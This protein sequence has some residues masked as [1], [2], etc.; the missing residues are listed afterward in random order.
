[1]PGS[2]K[3]IGFQRFEALLTTPVLHLVNSVLTASDLLTLSALT[4][5]AIPNNTLRAFA[6]DIAYLEAW[7]RAVF[8]EGLSF[9]ADDELGLKFLAHHLFLESQRQENS[10]HGMPQ[11]IE[12]ALRGQGALKGAL[13]HSPSTVRRRFSSWRK[14]HVIKGHEEALTSQALQM[15]IRA[16]ATAQKRRP[17]RKSP[18][19]ITKA[20]LERMIGTGS[21]KPFHDAR[22]L[23]DRALVLFA[24]ASGGRR[25]SEM[26]D[27][28]WS[29]MTLAEEGH[30]ALISLS[31][32]KTTRSEDD[33]RVAVAGRA[34]EY[35][36]A[37]RDRL[38][39]IEGDD[40]LKGPI[41]PGIDVWGNVLP[42]GLT[43][44]AVSDIVAKFIK[45]AGLDPAQYTS[46]G[47][48]SG[49]LTEARNRNIPI[50]AAMLHTKHKSQKSAARYY[51]ERDLLASEAARLLDE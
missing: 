37:W 41:F 40:A 47:F 1:M 13:P 30:G 48:R 22:E 43:G 45:R 25:R 24:F 20:V 42:T 10:D 34:F 5:A 29:D 31:D 9:P 7:H 38:C 26:R 2:D 51:D 8:G 28:Y 4:K 19:P 6:S 3:T 35:L 21:P 16:A 18:K 33:E 39:V 27:L 23:R 44:D 36:M 15:A 50:E 14:A 17:R 11:E 49:F 46:H 32:T 12:A